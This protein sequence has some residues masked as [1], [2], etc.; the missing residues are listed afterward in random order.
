MKISCKYW[1]SV[2]QLS[3]TCSCKIYYE[4]NQMTDVRQILAPWKMFNPIL[5]YKKVNLI[6]A[7]VPFTSI[8]N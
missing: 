5:R 3:F 1:V 8:V 4:N 7:D 2:L 6:F